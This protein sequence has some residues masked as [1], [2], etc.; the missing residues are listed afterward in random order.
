PGCRPWDFPRGW[1]TRAGVLKV[2]RSPP[3]AR[4]TRPGVSRSAGRGR[5]QGRRCS[6]TTGLASQSCQ[7]TAAT[8]QVQRSAAVG[9]RSRTVVQPRCC[10]AK[11]KACSTVKRLRYQRQTWCRSCGKSPPIQAS[12]SGIGWPCCGRC[13]T[14]THTTV[15]GAAGAS[16][17]CRSVQAST[18]TVPYTGCSRLAERSAGPCVLASWSLKTGPCV[19]GRPQPEYGCGAAEDAVLGE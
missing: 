3:K 9:E 14:C 8:S 10:L 12:H 19:C 17:T 4:C 2:S 18:V 5:S 16:W 7:N 15:N 1:G 11:R 13:S 6:A